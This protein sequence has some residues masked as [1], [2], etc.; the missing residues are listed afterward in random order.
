MALKVFVIFFLKNATYDIVCRELVKEV[1][2]IDSSSSSDKA[3][4]VVW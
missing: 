2:I 4:K 3:R 1:E